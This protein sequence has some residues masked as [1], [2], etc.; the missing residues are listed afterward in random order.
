VTEDVSFQEESRSLHQPVS[1]GRERRNGEHYNELA[2]GRNSRGEARLSAD[3][4]KRGSKNAGAISHSH[5]NCERSACKNDPPRLSDS[6]FENNGHQ[7][8]NRIS[9]HIVISLDILSILET[10][11]IPLDL[12]VDFPIDSMVILSPRPRGIWSK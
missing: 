6:P 2:D 5:V 4:F 1:T 12:P 7:Q 8:Q 9:V 11:T 3:D 10:D